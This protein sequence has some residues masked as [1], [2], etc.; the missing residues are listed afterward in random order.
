MTT[1]KALLWVG[2]LGVGAFVLYQVL[3]PRDA[4][5]SSSQTLPTSTSFVSGLLN[6]L[7]SI[8]GGPTNGPNQYGP[9]TGQSAGWNT[10]GIDPE[11]GGVTLAPGE[12][13]GPP[14]PGGGSFEPYAPGASSPGPYAPG[15]GDFFGPPIP[16]S[17]DT[18][19]TP[20]F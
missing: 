11:T 15:G 18:L 17:G 13:Y 7:P 3:K 6:V 19:L 20:S 16:G 5:A 10:S 9:N 12:T 1:T 2:G 4:R 14:S 8:F